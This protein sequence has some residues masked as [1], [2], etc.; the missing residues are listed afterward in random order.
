MHA[1]IREYS[2]ALM[3]IKSGERFRDFGQVW[4]G[5]LATTASVCEYSTAVPRVYNHEEDTQG[6]L[7]TGHRT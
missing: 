7:Q 1:R 5:C 6:H 4:R 3:L 2:P